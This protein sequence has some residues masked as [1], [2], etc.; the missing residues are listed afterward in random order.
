MTSISLQRSGGNIFRITFL[1][2]KSRRRR[3][4]G[5]ERFP[6]PGAVGPCI[7]GWPHRY[8][9]RA[10]SAAASERGRASVVQWWHRARPSDEG[11]GAMS[12][13]MQMPSAATEQPQIAS[14]A[15]PWPPD[16]AEESI[17]GTDWHQ[18]RRRSGA[19][20][21]GALAGQRPDRA[22]RLRSTGRLTLPRPARCL[23]LCAPLRPGSRLPR[24]RR[25]RPVGVHRRG[26]ERVN[27]PQRP[28][29][30]GRQGLQLRPWRRGRVSRAGP[31][32][33]L[34][35]RGHP[36]LATR[37][38]SLRPLAPRSRWPLAQQPRLRDRPGRWPG[39]GLRAGRAAHPAPGRGRGGAVAPA[40]RDRA[41]APPARRGIARAISARQGCR[42]R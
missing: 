23:R 16:D 42:G 19:R 24:P 8:S 30:D 28:R 41:A 11:S 2:R 7:P 13:Q 10:D 4:F 21:A 34:P 27:L 15:R 22:P 18:A 33:P 20:R 32:P 40:G 31:R 9:A 6:D 17:V 37:R 14:S 25:R 1:V 12:G 29:P 5:T 26:P 39:G 36:R 38:R 3:L 35:Q